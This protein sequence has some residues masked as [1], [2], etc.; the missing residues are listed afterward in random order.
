MKYTRYQLLFAAIS[1]TVMAWVSLSMSFAYEDVISVSTI[2]LIL[3]PFV[4][5][6]GGLIVGFCYGWCEEK[7]RKVEKNMILAGFIFVHV[8]VA[9]LNYKFL[10]G[11]V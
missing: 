9:F 3:L 10:M 1:G 6:C 8:V 2:H 4:S 11:L 7:S 5:F